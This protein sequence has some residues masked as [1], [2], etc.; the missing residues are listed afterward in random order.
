MTIYQGVD[1]GFTVRCV[2]RDAIAP[3]SQARIYE[4]I[5]HSAVAGQGVAPREGVAQAVEQVGRDGGQDASCFSYV[6]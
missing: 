4:E 1:A 5:A 6:F 2:F 3:G